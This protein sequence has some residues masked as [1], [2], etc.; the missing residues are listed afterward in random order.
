MGGL[1]DLAL[2]EMDLEQRKTLW[3]HD[4]DDHDDD[5]TNFPPLGLCWLLQ[6]TEGPGR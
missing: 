4:D 5:G 2:G 6:G 3:S 1:I